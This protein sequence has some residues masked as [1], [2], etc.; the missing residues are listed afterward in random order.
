VTALTSLSPLIMMISDDADVT[1]HDLL[2]GGG[3]NFPSY[4]ISIR[5]TGGLKMTR[6]RVRSSPHRLLSVPR[7]LGSLFLAPAADFPVTVS[8]LLHILVETIDCSDCSL[9]YGS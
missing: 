5:C 2:G 6:S 8:G 4:N 1:R 3:I 9:S 7:L